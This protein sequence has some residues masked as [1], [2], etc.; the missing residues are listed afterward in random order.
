L[1]IQKGSSAVT[2]G[3]YSTNNKAVLSVSEV[4]KIYFRNEKSEFTFDSSGFQFNRDGENL[5][6]Y[7]T[8]FRTGSGNSVMS[9]QKWW[10]LSG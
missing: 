7:L 5:K 2:I 6:K 8:G 4:E 9:W 1:I 3:I 10:F